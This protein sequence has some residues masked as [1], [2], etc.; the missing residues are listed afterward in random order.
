MAENLPTSP[1]PRHALPDPHRVDEELS[2]PLWIM[3][4]GVGAGAFWSLAGRIDPSP[5]GEER[6]P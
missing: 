1:A 6:V 2:V 4:A 5:T 3:L